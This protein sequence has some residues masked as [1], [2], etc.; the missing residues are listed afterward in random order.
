MFSS[1]SRWLR[2]SVSPPRAF[3]ENGTHQCTSRP[4]KIYIK[5]CVF[6]STHSHTHITRTVTSMNSSRDSPPPPLVRPSVRFPISKFQESKLWMTDYWSC[7]AA[8]VW[9]WSSGAPP[10]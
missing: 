9:W 8:S 1:Y 10:L 3:N 5:R 7:T 6:L 2:H 4:A